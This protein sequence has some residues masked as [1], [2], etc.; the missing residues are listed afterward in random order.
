MQLSSRTGL[1]LVLELGE[2]EDNSNCSLAVHHCIPAISTSD[3]TSDQTHQLFIARLQD[4]YSGR[5]QIV[6][7]P[8][9]PVP[10]SGK[11]SLY[12]AEGWENLC[13]TGWTVTKFSQA[14]FSSL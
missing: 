5:Y 11:R 7:P 14:A 1:P 13:K 12:E 8:L 3:F 10:S 9:V 4:F 2:A 6:P